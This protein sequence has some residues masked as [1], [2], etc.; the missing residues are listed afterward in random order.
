MNKERMR[1]ILIVLGSAIAAASP[2][3]D[4][5][6][7]KRRTMVRAQIEARGVRD[8]RVLEAMRRVPRHIFV[9]PAYRDEAY[10]DHPLPIGEG[11]TISQPYVV[12]VMTE[13]L[14][15]KPTDR[16]LEIGTGSGYQA[17]ILA[18]LVREVHT[19]EIIPELGERA[20]K[21]LAESGFDNVFVSIGDGYRGLPAKAP[22][23]GIIV[24]A[25]PT[26]VPKPLLDQLRIGGRLVIPV[27]SWDQELKV[28]TR[29]KDGFE[30]RSVF[31]VRFVPM[32]GEAER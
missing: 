8:A 31:G 25:A 1:D 21:V 16:V 26:E 5:Y 7:S 4:P 14:E 28:Y 19:I 27:G 23:D 17:A 12:A 29:T 30:S 3:D 24:T 10:E 6:L 2:A 9:P 32:T 15:P 20:R 13:L 18:E 22:F 11:Q